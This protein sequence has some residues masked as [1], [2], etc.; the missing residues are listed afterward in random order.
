[1]S[2]LDCMTILKEQGWD[3]LR[4]VN[5]MLL[6]A[7]SV[8]ESGATEAANYRQGDANR[9]QRMLKYFMG[10]AMQKTKGRADPEQ[11]R[12]LIEQVLQERK[13]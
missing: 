7:Q 11:M 13:D 6:I 12:S 5:E 10:Q 4:D 1:P 8:V 3:V 2:Q 9:K